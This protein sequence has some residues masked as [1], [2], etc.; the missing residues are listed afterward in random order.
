MPTNF[1]YRDFRDVG[2]MLLPFESAARFRSPFI[3]RVVTTFEAAETDVDA[4]GDTFA[5]PRPIAEGAGE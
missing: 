3:G 2:G 1:R 5:P 4:P